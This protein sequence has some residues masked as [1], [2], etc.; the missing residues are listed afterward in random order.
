LIKY[1]VPIAI[2]L[3]LLVGLKILQFE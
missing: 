2:V 1:V 3:V